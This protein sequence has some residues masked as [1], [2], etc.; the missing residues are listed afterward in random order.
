[1]FSCEKVKGITLNGKTDLIVKIR[2]PRTQNLLVQFKNP[3]VPISTK[4]QMAKPIV[5]LEK[6]VMINEEP[7][8]GPVFQKEKLGDNCKGWDRLSVLVESKQQNKCFWEFVE[9]LK[10]LRYT[11]NQI[12]DKKWRGL[13]R[14]LRRKK[15]VIEMF[16]ETR[17]KIA[18]T[19]ELVNEGEEGG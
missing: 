19:D 5:D 16:Q 1:M 12:V 6:H 14:Y 17:K 11:Y 4:R 7:N 15:D 8:F 13:P 2:D 10:N 9:R 18:H 3:K